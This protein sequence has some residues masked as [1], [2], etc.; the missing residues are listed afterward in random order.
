[1]SAHGATDLQRPARPE[2]KHGQ[3][4]SIGGPEYQ[5]GKAIGCADGGR[6]SA[7]SSMQLDAREE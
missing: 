7:R 5:Y 4:A 2:W 6:L 3:G 1:M